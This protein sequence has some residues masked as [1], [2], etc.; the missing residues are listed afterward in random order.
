MAKGDQYM[1]LYERERKKKGGVHYDISSRERKARTMVAV[2]KDF[3][4]WPL[5]KLNVLDI[6]GST[7][8]ID[9]YLS[10]YFG[11]IIGIDINYF[12]IQH[13]K[14]TYKKDNLAFYLA[15][16]LNLPFSNESF[17]VVICSHIYEHV[18]DSNKLFEEIFRVLKSEGVCYFAAGNRLALKESHYKLPLLSVIPRPLAHFYIRKVGKDSHY[19]IKLFS[20]WG[21]KALV[22]KFRCTD[23]TTKIISESKKYY[24]DYMIPPNSFKSRVGKIVLKYLYWLSPGYIWLLQ[25]PYSARNTIP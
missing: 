5:N 14:N 13:A 21:L 7:G 4:E 18:P 6:G 15:D 2:L 24:A 9:N 11:R 10:S 23:Y 16:A 3:I 20:Y 12:S 8:I 25:K 17:D 22:K 1:R 19:D